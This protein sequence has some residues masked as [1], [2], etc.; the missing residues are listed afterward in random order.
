MT[1]IWT[2]FEV[3]SVE[4]C[5]CC[6]VSESFIM[7]M[8]GVWKDA[9]LSELSISRTAGIDGKSDNQMAIANNTSA[10]PVTEFW[11]VWGW[12]QILVQLLMTELSIAGMALC[13][14]MQLV[15]LARQ[16]SSQ[17]MIETNFSGKGSN[18]V[19]GLIFILPKLQNLIFIWVT[20]AQP[21]CQ[22]LV[23]F[24]GMDLE[25]MQNYLSTCLISYSVI[26]YELA[27]YL[28]LGLETKEFSFSKF[29]ELV[30]EIKQKFPF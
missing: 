9:V 5:S 6:S 7:V 8:V 4:C 10:R 1:S 22:Q 11:Q 26:T 19:N 14:W 15:G 27:P 23:F 24:P 21:T 28:N 20:L 17:R 2:L 30:E 12:I 13:G 29:Q 3:R 25:L 16:V 18:R